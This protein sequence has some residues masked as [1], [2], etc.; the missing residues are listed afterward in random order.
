MDTAYHLLTPFELGFTELVAELE[1]RGQAYQTLA[2]EDGL[3]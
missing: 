1:D 3:P 2:P